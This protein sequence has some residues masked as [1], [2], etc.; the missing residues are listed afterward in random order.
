MAL[1]LTSFSRRD[2]AQM[3][4]TDLDFLK[5]LWKVRPTPSTQFTGAACLLSRQLS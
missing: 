5:V 4:M 1:I 2:A 3:D